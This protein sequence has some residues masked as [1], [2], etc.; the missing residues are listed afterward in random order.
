[1]ATADLGEV[2]E[3]DHGAY[4]LRNIVRV[5]HELTVEAN[6]HMKLA[7]SSIREC[8]DWRCARRRTDSLLLVCLDG[9]SLSRPVVRV[10]LI[11]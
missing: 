2:I 11:G 6:G 10:S 9:V 5:E 8:A 4:R 3:L 1:M 7:Q